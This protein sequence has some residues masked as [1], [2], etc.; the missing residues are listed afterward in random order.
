[1][2]I[3]TPREALEDPTASY[4]LKE[5]LEAAL[6]RDPVDAAADARE[7]AGVLG[8]HARKVLEQD[9]AEVAR[10][11]AGALKFRLSTIVRVLDEA[12]ALMVPD[13]EGLHSSDPDVLMAADRAAS[14]LH[15]EVQVLQGQRDNLALALSRALGEFDR[16]GI[17]DGIE[18]YRR[19][20]AEFGGPEFCTVPHAAVPDDN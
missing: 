15:A 3:P 9:M 2:K 7:L 4:W 20:L 5:A 18:W 17:S 12:L 13:L 11:A 8:E 14:R 10:E 6:T 1:M 16:H 19:T